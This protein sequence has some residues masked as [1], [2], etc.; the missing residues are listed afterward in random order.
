MRFSTTGNGT[1]AEVVCW[2]LADDGNLILVP[3]AATEISSGDTP[4][5]SSVI[6]LGELE[7][8]GTELILL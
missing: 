1:N 5:G 2:Q 4:D 6:W 3:N 8:V 7:C